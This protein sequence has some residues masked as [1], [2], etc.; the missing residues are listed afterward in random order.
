MNLVHSMNSVHDSALHLRSRSVWEAVDS[1]VLLWRSNF[2]YFILSFSVPVWV[3]ACGLRLL[4]E[5]LFFIPYISLWWLK[6]LFDRIVL[7]VVSKRFFDAPSN[8]DL[9]ALCRGIAEM[10]RGLLGDL[11]WRRFSPGRAAKMPIRVL[12]HL[13]S[14]Q[15]SQRKKILESGGINFCSFIGIL[16]LAL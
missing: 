11:L 7:Y 12:E 1:G 4:S 14:K 15:F 16:G 9:K 3:T 10:S 5:E 13:G 8:S 2:I 6:P